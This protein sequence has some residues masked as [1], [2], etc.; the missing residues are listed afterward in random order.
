MQQIRTSLRTSARLLR[1]NTMHCAYCWYYRVSA[2]CAIPVI[3]LAWR[4][5][6]AHGL[7]YVHASQLIHRDLKPANCFLLADGT[8]KIGDFGL[9]RHAA[10]AGE[11]F[12]Y[13]LE[14]DCAELVAVSLL[15]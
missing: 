8:V 13:V 10:G 11:P 6:V 9:S 2:M 12:K 3:V 5:Q 4:Q 15:H 14:V 1:T 7:K